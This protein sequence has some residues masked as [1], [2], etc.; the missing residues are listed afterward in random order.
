MAAPASGAQR[1][2]EGMGE[3]ERG[4]VSGE[5]VP[6]QEGW[7]LCRV[8]VSARS[9]LEWG[10]GS[11]VARK[12][13]W[14]GQT[15]SLLAQ[16]LAKPLSDASPSDPRLLEATP[17]PSTYAQSSPTLPSSL[18]PREPKWSFRVAPSPRPQGTLDLLQH[19]PTAALWPS[20]GQPIFRG[21][22]LAL[23]L[24]SPQP[25]C[26]GLDK[27][28]DQLSPTPE[29]MLAQTVGQGEVDIKRAQGVISRLTPGAP[30]MQIRGP[31]QKSAS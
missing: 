10:L 20:R 11:R 15:A 5:P 12:A 16:K 27:R 3:G 6:W 2:G 7:G 4:S 19:A 21:H 17:P 30:E 18:C 31:A 1:P 9:R 25:L 14:K 23:C 22:S 28:R 29:G 8:A 24:F 13:A 26:A